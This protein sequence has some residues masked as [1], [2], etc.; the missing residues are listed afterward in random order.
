VPTD[1]RFDQLFPEDQRVR[2]LLHWTPMKVARRVAELLGTS[3]STRV[4]DIG[5]GVGK[6]CLVGAQLTESTWCGVEQD[7]DMVAAARDAATTLG[8]GHRV[9]FIH[10][11]ADDVDWS[12]FDAFY[13]FNPFAEQL[14]GSDEGQAARKQQYVAMVSRTQERFEACASGTRVLT[15]HGFGGDLP[16]SYVVLH[17]EPALADELIL[18]EKQ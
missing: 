10:G 14:L 18:W 3:P 12:G 9:S 11:D 2:S 1:F 13:L 5:S 6:V 4:L 7:A 8:L 17:R 15:Y 16:S